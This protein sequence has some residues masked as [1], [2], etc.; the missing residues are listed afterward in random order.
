MIVASERREAP[1]FTIAENLCNV[2]SNDAVNSDYRLLVVDAPAI[3]LAA[4][5]G[6][7][8][9]LACP[10]RG[11]DQPLLRR[12]MS[13]YRIDRG[14]GQMSFLYKV[15]GAGTR[16]LATLAPGDTLDA[17]GPLGRG[18][19]IPDGTRHVLLLA[20]GVGLA[21]L[22]PLAELAVSLG[23][24]VTAVLSARSPELLMSEDYLRSVGARI[25]TVTDTVGDSDV[26][27]LE[28][29][30]RLIHAREPFDFLATCGSNRLL[31]LLQTLSE[32][33]NIPGE[34]AL[35]QNMG[36]GLG[37]CFA[38]V[39][40]FRTADGKQDYRRVCWDGPVFDLR[41][42]LPWLT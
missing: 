33:W 13:V 10:A 24:K 37:M 27:A 8:F 15:T 41:E 21:T 32:E 3:A 28:A 1:S 7:F 18:F 17:L 2:V 6:K 4:E 35:E 29:R 19:R 42:A 9:H 5:A 12:P 30:L 22:A 20:R 26:V 39:R 11:D 40:N 16:G 31:Q 14:C 38:C 23:A 34:V 36:C 25:E